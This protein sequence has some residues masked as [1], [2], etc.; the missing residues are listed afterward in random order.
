MPDITFTINRRELQRAWGILS[1]PSKNLRANAVSGQ[2]NKPA[3]PVGLWNAPRRLLLDKVGQAEFCDPTGGLGHCW[4]Q[5]FDD[6]HGVTEV[7]IH[8]DGG[9]PNATL[10]CIGIL[11]SNTKGW[12]DAFYS[13]SS[14]G[15]L[16]VEVVDEAPA[17]DGVHI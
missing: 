15:A 7:G 14:G 17:P 1:W 8:P 9:A 12:Y 11:D 5:A 6:A 16:S 13:I 3:I 10:G 2:S 4:F